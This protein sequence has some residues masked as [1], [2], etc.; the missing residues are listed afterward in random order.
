MIVAHRDDEN[1]SVPEHLVEE[2]SLESDLGRVATSD[3]LATKWQESTF[4]ADCSADVSTVRRERDERTGQL[5][6]V[7]LND[8]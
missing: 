1:R 2:P 7:I 4:H 6:V 5:Q 3:A 8:T